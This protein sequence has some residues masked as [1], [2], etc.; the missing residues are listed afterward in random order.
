MYFLDTFEWK[1]A[2]GFNTFSSEAKAKF[3]GM[4]TKD[5]LHYMWNNPARGQSPYRMFA[6]VLAPDGYDEKHDIIYRY[7]SSVTHEPVN[8]KDWELSQL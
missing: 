7:N 6:G 1:R 2:E 5:Y 4:T 8:W 3:A